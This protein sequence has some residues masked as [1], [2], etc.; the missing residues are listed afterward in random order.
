M[1]DRPIPFTL[2][3]RIDHGVGFATRLLGGWR[4]WSVIGAAILL[5][6][7]TGPFGTYGEA[8]FWPRL[9]YWAATMVGT[10]VVAVV[11]VALASA[12]AP[13]AWS[14]SFPVLMTGAVLSCLPNTLLVQSLIPPFLDRP[15]E[16]FSAMFLTVLPI[17]L[18]IGTVT[19]LVYEGTRGEPVD[20]AGTERTNALLERLPVEKRGPVIRMSMQDHYVEVVTARGREL[21]LMRMADAAAAMGRSGLRI[22]RS[23]WVARDHVAKARRDGAQAVVTTSDGAELPVSRSYVSALRSAGLL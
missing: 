1:V 9:V 2:R 23:H 16:S 12:G 4:Y 5:L 6:A 13:R 18:A 20:P 15:A 11:F 22:H 17:G 7:A 3:E 19:W 8:T 21:V 14:T 10:S